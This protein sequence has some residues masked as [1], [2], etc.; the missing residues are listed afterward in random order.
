[1]SSTGAGTGKQTL[2]LVPEISLTPSWSAVL[3]GVFAFR[4]R[5]CTPG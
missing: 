1:M 2:A 4:S 5:C 3:N